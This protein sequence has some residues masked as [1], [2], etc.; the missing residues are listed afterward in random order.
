VNFCLSFKLQR[1]FAFTVFTVCSLIYGTALTYTFL[2]Y[3]TNE[4]FL[5][6]CLLLPLTSCT[7]NV[8]A[9]LGH[10]HTCRNEIRNFTFA[11]TWRAFSVAIIRPGRHTTRQFQ[12]QRRTR[13][14]C[15][16]W[17]QFLD[18]LFFTLRFGAAERA[19]RTIV[20]RWVSGA[21][22]FYHQATRSRA[23]T[24]AFYPAGCRNSPY[25]TANSKHSK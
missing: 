19:V 9:T 17:L 12:S 24:L 16:P 6:V 13:F 15:V 7:A 14:F 5:L 20:N 11:V 8:H 1:D 3:W 23:L 22:I 18:P 10:T 21:I 4:G 25:F 2:I